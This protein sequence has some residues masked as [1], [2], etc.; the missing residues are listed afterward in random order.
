[1]SRR[2]DSHTIASVYRGLGELDTSGG[3]I[4]ATRTTKDSLYALTLDGDCY[5]PRRVE[6]L[7]REAIVCRYRRP[8][9]MG[10]G[11]E[12]VECKDFRTVP[13]AA[14]WMRRLK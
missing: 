12:P 10:E 8:F 5:A 9:D 13:L 7:N 6:A 2:R 3:C 14:A 11:H 4:W 1:M